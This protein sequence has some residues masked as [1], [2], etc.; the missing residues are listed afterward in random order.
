GGGADAGKHGMDES[1]G[2]HAAAAGRA[3]AAPRGDQRVSRKART[4]VTPR[5]VALRTRLSYLAAAAFLPLA[6]MSGVGL[7][8]LVHQQRE[9][10]ER[11]GIEVTRALSTAV[12]AELQRSMSALGGA[13]FRAGAR[14]PGDGT[15]LPG[16]RQ[17][18]GNQPT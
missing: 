14:A 13:R 8:A 6:L 15:L 4:Q 18:S 11:A 5:N 17:S 1:R 7:L 2:R 10:A 12:D 3:A 16:D 9:Q